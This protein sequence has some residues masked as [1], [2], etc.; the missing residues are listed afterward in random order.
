MNFFFRFETGEGEDTVVLCD[1]LLC[2]TQSDPDRS[3]SPRMLLFRSMSDKVQGAHISLR[4]ATGYSLAG[5]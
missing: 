5:L 4:S 2:R 1:F 3:F